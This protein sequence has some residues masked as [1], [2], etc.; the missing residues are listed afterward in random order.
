MRLTSRYSGNRKTSLVS[1]WWSIVPAVSQGSLK[2]KFGTAIGNS[3]ALGGL[4]NADASATLLAESALRH[5]AGRYCK[6]D[7]C[8]HPSCPLFCVW[9]FTDIPADCGYRKCQ[10]ERGRYQ[11]EDTKGNTQKRSEIGYSGPQGEA[12]LS[13]V[14]VTFHKH[15]RPPSQ[16]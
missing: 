8:I 5:Q 3:L 12:E 4:D 16:S 2:E 7:V 13:E 9:K 10:R 6:N 15:E 14:K 11:C 1:N